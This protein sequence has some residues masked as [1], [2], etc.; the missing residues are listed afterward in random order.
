MGELLYHW[1]AWS[2]LLYNMMII[3]TPAIEMSSNK[4]GIHTTVINE[5]KY[6]IFTFKC[7][8]RFPLRRFQRKTNTKIRTMVSDSPKQSLVNLQNNYRNC[9]ILRRYLD[10]NFQYRYKTHINK[11]MF[12]DI[13]NKDQIYLK[14]ETWRGVAAIVVTSEQ[15][16]IS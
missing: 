4:N 10:N 6:G 3:Q 8:N 15:K 7:S 14:N 13:Y 16:Q 1:I 2:L 5:M 11:R 9:E 12:R